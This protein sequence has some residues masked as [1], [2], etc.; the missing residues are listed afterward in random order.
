MEEISE[1]LVVRMDVHIVSVQKMVNHGRSF[2]VVSAPRDFVQ[3]QAALGICPSAHEVIEE[4]DVSIRCDI[5]EQ[6]I[7]P[8]KHEAVARTPVSSATCVRLIDVN[9]LIKQPVNSLTIVA[10]ISVAQINGRYAKVKSNSL[11]TEGWYVHRL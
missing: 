10:V 2:V 8:V 1:I 7:R 3:S 9:A 5:I 11:R 4:T 6:M